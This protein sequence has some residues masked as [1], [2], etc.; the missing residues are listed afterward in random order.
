MIV[1]MVVLGGALELVVHVHRTGPMLIE[2]AATMTLPMVAWMRY[3]GHSWLPCLE[4]TA[5]MVIPTLGT[6]ALLGAGIVEGAG[7]LMLIEH[8]VMLPSML[9]AMLLRREEYSCAHG[10][11]TPVEAAA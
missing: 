5:S 11:V 7:P 4:M 10:D 2:M 8:V 3:R 6:L 9:V 1:G